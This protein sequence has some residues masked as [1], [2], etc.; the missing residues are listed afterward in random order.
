MTAARFLQAVRPEIAEHILQEADAV[1][2]PVRYAGA[3]VRPWYFQGTVALGESVRS[4]PVDVALEGDPLR[5]QSGHELKRILNRDGS[6]SPCVEEEAGRREQVNLADRI[7]RRLIAADDILRYHRVSENCC[8]RTVLR[9][10][11]SGC[12]QVSAGREADDRDLIRQDVPFLCMLSD[13]A[14]GLFVV[15]QRI[16]PLS[17]FIYRVAKNKRVISGSQIGHCDRLSF[18]VGAHAVSSAREDQNGRAGGDIAKFSSDRQDISGK[19]NISIFIQADRFVFHV[20]AP[21]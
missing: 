3:E 4:V 11:G 6:V 9:H 2:D 13:I 21:F 8:V 18:P 19:S 17:V 10:G 15:I 12:G 1:C 5:C 14:H 7:R 20:L 16:G